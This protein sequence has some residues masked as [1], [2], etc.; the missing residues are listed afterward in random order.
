MKVSVIIP[1][2]NQ[3]ELIIKAL[4]SLPER[5]DIEAIVID[6]GSTDGTR[7]AVKDYMAAH[8]DKNIRLFGFKANKGVSAAC[9]KGLE[10]AS[11][12]YVV[13]LGSD[14]YFL[15]DE[16][17]KAL[18]LLD[19]TDLV[20]FNL[21]IN[22]GSLYRLTEATKNYFCGS[23]KFMRRAFIK[24]LRYPE[25]KKA[26]EDWYFNNELQAR[27]PTETFSGLTAK[28]YNFPREGS[29]VD[30]RKRGIIKGAEV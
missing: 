18:D 25:E 30:L 12:E 11:G 7:N 8:L 27:K 14:D 24:G 1:V 6:D 29:L 9:N 28:H 22:D 17:L 4:D 21:R 23:T 16:F 19:G 13:L 3:E 26:G 15:T 20:Y 5:E 10:K 2:W